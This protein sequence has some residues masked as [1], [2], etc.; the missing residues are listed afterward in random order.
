MMGPAARKG[1]TP[2]TARQS[3]ASQEAQ[4]ATDDAT[5]AG[6]SGRAF[7][8]LRVLFVREV[9][10]RRLVGKERRD[11]IVREAG[12]LEGVDD[13]AGARL[14]R[15]DADYGLAH[16]NLQVLVKVVSKCRR[17]ASN[18]AGPGDDSQDVRSDRSGI[19]HQLVDDAFRA[20]DGGG[21]HAAMASFSA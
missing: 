1:P 19:D 20:H 10:S 15:C 2:G 17:W 3:E 9:T 16:W 8:G 14:V 6:A 21:L 5:C 4:P 13:P 12:L 11:A 18:G 7:R